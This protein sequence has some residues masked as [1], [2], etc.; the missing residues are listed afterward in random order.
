M[1]FVCLNQVFTGICLLTCNPNNNNNNNN[2]IPPTR[3]YTV[4]FISGKIHS[5]VPV[6]SLH[7]ALQDFLKCCFLCIHGS[8]VHIKQS[9]INVPICAAAMLYVLILVQEQLATMCKCLCV[10]VFIF[11]TYIREVIP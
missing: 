8:H 2:N 7:L 11:S 9:V 6:S 1:I 3:N 4:L 5:V 10:Q